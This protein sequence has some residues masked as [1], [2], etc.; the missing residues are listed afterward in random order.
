MGDMKVDSST[1]QNIQPTSDELEISVPAELQLKPEAHTTEDPAV[2]ANRAEAMKKAGTE[3]KGNMNTSV[4]YLKKTLGEQLRMGATI[5]GLVDKLRAAG[6]RPE[7]I[8]IM[9]TKMSA[10]AQHSSVEFD[11][12]AALIHDALSTANP[13]RLTQTIVNLGKTNNDKPQLVEDYPIKPGSQDTI[14][15]NVKRV[16][17]YVGDTAQYDY[18]GLSTVNGAGLKDYLT[19]INGGRALTDFEKNLAAQWNT[20]GFETAVLTPIYKI[21]SDEV[22]AYKLET[23]QSGRKETTIYDRNGTGQVY[24]P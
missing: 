6:I 24:D 12:Q 7:L 14:K 4:E 5:D 9:K 19:K 8:N 17:E 2:A 13:E 15:T 21:G 10:L 23:G 3:N 1:A 18:K 20:K 11:R 16:T 22:E